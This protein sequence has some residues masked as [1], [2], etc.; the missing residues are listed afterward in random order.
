MI[1]YKKLNK[2]ILFI[3]GIILITICIYI[4]I[5]FSIIC[6]KKKIK[7]RQSSEMMKRWKNQVQSISDEIDDKESCSLYSNN[8]GYRLGDMISNSWRWKNDG[9]AYHYKHFPNSI[10]TEYMKKTKEYYNYNVL[11]DIISERTKYTNDLPDKNDIVVHL[12]TGDVIE[13]NPDDVI[14][15]L[16][17]YSYIDKNEWSNYTPPLEYLYNKISKININKIQKIILVS[18]SH[19]Y[20]K[21]PKS[22]KYIEIVKKYFEYKGYQVELRLG[23][24]SDDDF[25]FMCNA[26]YFVPS[27]SGGYTKLITNIV[28]MM[29]NQVL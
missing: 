13:Q 3:S 6:C 8:K 16:S 26:R 22:C 14:T 10:A 2:Y 5:S 17:T 24:N 29:G 4:I 18:G 23:M 19:N 20:S 27:T 11:F 9:Q 28:K 1:V 25:I 7:H 15:I 21:T 12:R